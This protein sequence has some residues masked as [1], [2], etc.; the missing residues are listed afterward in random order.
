MECQRGAAVGAFSGAIMAT[1]AGAT[2]LVGVL[3]AASASAVG[4]LI[5]L[6]I[7]SASAEAPEDDVLPPPPEDR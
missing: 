1:F 5:A 3:A 6:L 7:W 2:P 4:A